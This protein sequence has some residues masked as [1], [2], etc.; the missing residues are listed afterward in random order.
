MIALLAL[1]PATTALA[2]CHRIYDMVDMKKVTCETDGYYLLKCNNCGYTVKK[3]TDKAHGHNRA[4]VTSVAEIRDEHGYDKFVCKNCM[5]E[6][7]C[8][9]CTWY[10]R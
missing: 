5:E 4:F 1:L 10:M 7:C 3:S 8:T 2:E 6:Q 9:L